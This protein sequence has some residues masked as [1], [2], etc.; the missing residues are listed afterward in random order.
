MIISHTR[1]FVFV[2]SIK[3]AGTSIEAALSNYC[4]DNDIVTP[5][6]NY[7]FNRDQASPIQHRSMNAEHLGWWHKEIGQHVDAATIRR[8]HEGPWRDYNKISIARNPWDR[9]VSLFFWLAR[10]DESLKPKKRFYH[11][12]G[13]PF[14]EIDETKKLFA[15]FVKKGDWE[16]NDRFYM[17]NDKVCVD[18]II[19]YES[20]DDD[21]NEVCDKLSLPRIDLPRLKTGIRPMQSHYSQYYDNESREIVAERHQNDIR[22]FGYEFQNA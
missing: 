16:T 6:N 14:N 7:A 22:C 1:R 10:N 4:S 8:Y 21:F 19:R 3:T 18:F 12:L 15:Q 5:L 9:A 17:M 13:I 2:K 11:R 20:L